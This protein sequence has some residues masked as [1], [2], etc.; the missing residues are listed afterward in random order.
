MFGKAQRNVK[1]AQPVSIVQK[2]RW[3]A[4][5]VLPALLPIRSIP[6]VFKSAPRQLLCRGVKYLPKSCNK[7]LYF[8]DLIYYNI[9]T[10]ASGGMADAYGS[11]PYGRKSL[12]VQ[13]PSRPF[14]F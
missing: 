5:H 3:V 1:F 9:Y 11:G 7:I 4:P 8:C 6:L 10:W 14:L 13:L 12:R 2:G